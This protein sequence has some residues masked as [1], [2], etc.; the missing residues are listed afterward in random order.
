MEFHDAWFFIGIFVFIFLIWIATGGP[1]HPIAFTG[2]TLAQPGQ[3]GGGT[4]L[5]LPRAPFGVGSANVSL[6]GS[7][8]GESVSNGATNSSAPLPLFPGGSLFGEPSPY[9][10]V[11]SMS[12][13]VSGAGSQDPNNEYIEIDV[14]QDASM[15]IDLT[16]WTLESDATGDAV[17]IPKGT[18]VPTSGIVNEAQDIVLVPGERALVISGQS[19]I[20][21]SFRENKCIGYF[22][23][24]QNFSPPLPQDC[25]VP[26][27]EL[28]AFYGTGYIRD[29]ACIDYVNSLSRCQV[30]LT[31]PP[32]ASSACQSFL[33][34][35]LNY[36][37]CVDAH[38]SDAD[39]EGDTWR[40]YLGR[41]N[42]MW[43]TKNELVKLLDINGKTVDAFSY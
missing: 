21:A 11:V 15:P 33:I 37:G 7:S 36:N 39:F 13:Y 4:Y 43:R 31:P 38:R 27:D 6:P 20:G 17:V 14:A 24:F 26:S 28:S 40:L 22:S 35:Y 32:G 2:P 42:S 1:M 34:K 18:E 3:L 25:P 29:A 23:T 8:N 12:H 5:S 16:G 30:A 41:T 9:R 10:G 19:P